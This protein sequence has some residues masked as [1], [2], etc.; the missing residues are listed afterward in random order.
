MS[1]WQPFNRGSVALFAPP[2]SGV[3]AIARGATVIYVGQSLNL[4]SRLADHLSERDNPLLASLVGQGSCT[5]ACADVNPA[6]LDLVERRWI[7]QL[8]PTCNRRAA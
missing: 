6:L 3:Y 2:R 7:A 8:R 4:R 1:T 5:F